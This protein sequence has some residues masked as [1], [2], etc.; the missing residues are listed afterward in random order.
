MLEK[1][2]SARV[3]GISSG[4][5]KKNVEPTSGRRCA[6]L[7]SSPRGLQSVL[8][9]HVIRI[10]GEE[11]SPD[12]K[13]GITKM[14]AENRWANLKLSMVAIDGATPRNLATLVKKVAL[15]HGANEQAQR[16]KYLSLLVSPP[17]IAS[18]ATVELQR[19]S[20]HLQ[21]GNGEPDFQ[22]LVTEIQ[23]TT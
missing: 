2:G 14:L 3:E 13:M 21:K 17:E 23:D 7:T 6:R 9:V 5:S 10:I 1:L 19:C 16:S 8:S 18:K 4:R 22:K 12:P 20:T 15:E 11:A